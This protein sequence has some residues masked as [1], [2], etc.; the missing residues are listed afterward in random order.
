MK[1]E[2]TAQA[3][4]GRRRFTA[5]QKRLVGLILVLAVV[6]VAYRLVYA[7]GIAHTAALY[8]GVPTIL[9]I[10][11]ALLP[12]SKSATRMLL[13]GST[14]AV[15]IACV[16]LPEGFLCLLFALPLVL[17]IAGAVGE[18]VDWGRRKNRPEGQTLMAISLPLL[19][20]SLEGVVGTPFDTHDSVLATIVVEAPAAAVEAAVASTP[21]FDSD[22]PPFLELG[23]NRP[24]AATGSGVAV[25]DERMIDFAGGTHDDH[26]LRLFG[27]TGE[28]S[29]DHRSRMHLTV[30]ES[31]PG[32]VVF[33]VVHDMTMLA[34][35][36]DLERAVVMWTAVDD[37]TTLVSWR[38]EYERLIYP[39]AYFA[40]LQRFGMNQAA[41]YLL[42]SVVVEQ[43]R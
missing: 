10:G 43:L 20:M 34:R 19:L 32:R 23:F 18:I 8:V 30:V 36:A 35:W 24:V 42:D 33:A 13:K 39:S 6:N 11:L 22:L 27:L 25:G 7:T 38:L 28:R 29:V 5:A 12:R 2:P 16:I 4:G 40:P 31:E 15:L 9:A 14:L 41:G 17:V 26:P 1:V 21:R 37:D 3:G